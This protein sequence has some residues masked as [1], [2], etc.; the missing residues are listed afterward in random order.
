M[1]D[2]A[3]DAHRLSHCAGIAPG[4]VSVTA[5]QPMG[6][7]TIMPAPL[8]AGLCVHTQAQPGQERSL[9]VRPPCMHARARSAPGCGKCAP[10]VC[11]QEPGAHPAVGSAHTLY[12]RKSQERTRLWEVRTPFR[13]DQLAQAPILRVRGSS[14]LR[15]R[16][17]LMR[18]CLCVASRCRCLSG[19]VPKGPQLRDLNMGVHIAI[20]TPGRLNDFL[21]AGQVCMRVCV[22]VVGRS[23]L[24][25]H[26]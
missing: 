18:V 13:A 5:L 2:G 15:C 7:N 14:R 1:M 17:P 11:T 6:R 8:A 16:T 23:S 22:F 20:A 26:S 9:A 24:L 3:R 25:M 21:E 19:G 12:A 10:P 4:I